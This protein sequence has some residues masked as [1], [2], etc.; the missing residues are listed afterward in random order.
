VHNLLLSKPPLPQS[1]ITKSRSVSNSRNSDSDRDR[2]KEYL[3]EKF[4][5][6]RVSLSSEPLLNSREARNEKK[7]SSFRSRSNHAFF[8]QRRWRVALRAPVLALCLNHSNA[9]L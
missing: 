6:A 8:R 7:D 3:R 9:T 4:F 2:S 1:S 5:A